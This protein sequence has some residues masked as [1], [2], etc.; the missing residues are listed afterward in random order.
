M[1]YRNDLAYLKNQATYNNDLM[2][3]VFENITDEELKEKYP[4]QPIHP[5]AI[6]ITGQQFGQLK[7]LWKVGNKREGHSSRPIYAFRCECG[8]VKFSTSYMARSNQLMS[9]GKCGHQKGEQEI[10]YKDKFNLLN[11]RVGRLTI[12]ENL[13]SKNNSRQWKCLCDC[14]NEIIANTTTLNNNKIKSCGCVI[15]DW[16]WDWLKKGKIKAD[17]TINIDKPLNTLVGLYFGHLHIIEKTQ[18]RDSSKNIMWKCEC[19]CG[20]IINTSL[21]HLRLGKTSCG[22]DSKKKY[23]EAI[24]KI[25]IGDKFGKL[26][27]IKSENK[28]GDTHLYWICKCDC[29]KITNPI[30]S[31][32]LISGETQSCGCINYSI[33]ETNIMKILDENKISYFYNLGYFKDLIL[34]SGGIARYDFI[35]FDLNNKPIWIIEFD[36]RQHFE[37]VS[38]FKSSL[39]EIQISDNIKNNYASLKGIPLIRIPYELRDK[40]TLELLFDD[41]YCINKEKCNNFNKYQQWLRSQF[42]N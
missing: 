27:T 36:G 26:T 28:N 30:R 21:P 37:E 18:F 39:K 25:K 11:T 8:N 6:D 3:L 22:C 4:P 41:K 35:L 29:G 33:G 17:K 40:I 23:S 10:R 7:A 38:Y 42:N 9:C 15:Y 12:I 14:G 13:P 31:S 19:D 24:S 5:N 34:P 16:V 1:A 20:N 2:S 32:C